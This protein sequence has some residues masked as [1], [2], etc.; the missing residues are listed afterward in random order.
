[1]KRSL[2]S[3][4][5]RVPAEQEVDDELALHLELR[6]RELMERGMDERAARAEARRRM[7]D[8]EGVRRELLDLSRRRERAMNLSQAWDEFRTDVRFALRQMRAAPLFAVVAITTLALGIGANGAIFALVDAAL[9]RPLP[10]A[11]PERLVAIRETTAAGAEGSASPLNLADWNARS[12]AFEQIAGY[13]GGVGGMVMAG[14][15]GNAET[16]SRQWTTAGIFDVLGV[17]AIAGRTFERADDEKRA[18]VVVLN[19]AF[20]RSRF[21]ADPS[22]VGREIRLDGTMF[23]IVGV[24]PEWFRLVGPSS[25]WAMRPTLNLPERARGVYAFSA[26]GRLRPG[27]TLDA[28]LRDLRGVASALSSEYPQTNAGRSVSMRPMRDAFVGSDLRLTSM[29]FLGVVGFVLLICCANVANLLLA[30]ATA[31]SR[32]LAIRAA[33]GGGRRRIARQLITES[34]V[35]STLGGTFGLALGAATLAVA[36]SLIPDGIVP[37]T[38]TLAF[39]LRVALFCALATLA[40]G[41]VF[42]LAPAVQAT[43]LSPVEA[44]GADVRTTAGGGGRFREALVMS[45]VATAV[46][47]LF[48]A[49]LLLRSLAEVTSFDRGYRAESVLTMLVDPLGSKYPT[50]E[51][52]QQFLDEVEREARSAPGVADV[53]WTSALPLG[54]FDTGGLSYEIVGDEPLDA[55]RRP[56]TEYQVVSPS[57]FAAVELPIVAGRPFDAR[58]HRTGP[59]VAIVN[60]AFVKALGGRSPIGLFIA[61]RSSG[62]PQ[63]E[64]RIREIV[65]VAKQVKGSPDE[66]GDF[67]QVYAP[68]TQ[69]PTDDIYLVARPSSGSAEALTAGLR[70]AISRVDREQLVS[71]RDIRTLADIEW[72]AVGRHRFRALLVGAFAFLALV[73]AMVG[74]FGILAYSVQQRVRD[75]GVRRALGASTSHIVRDLTSYGARVI[76]GGAAC[77]LVLAAILSRLIVAVLFGVEPLDLATFAGVL[78]I[79]ASGGALSILG[80]AWRAARIDPVAALRTK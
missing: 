77:G 59:P 71:V 18:N 64:P 66:R 39:D 79:L 30:R 36:P 69:A 16:V 12:R 60:E 52:L 2:R 50:P 74:V 3:I 80:P 23:T 28:G 37:A 47:L 62:S 65:G 34:L 20:W 76:G 7:G 68:I 63:A 58:D 53:G 27:V 6:A 17:K 33:L 56:T 15:D 32:E 41:V 8:V 31:R 24:V 57:Y 26:V 10:F 1:M 4:L 44:M 70:A 54:A 11:D 21:D 9:L 72:D 55:G 42:G 13:V 22:I 40:V 48:G 46:L 73:L 61:L 67:V 51:S 14:R 5:W 38:V 25:L 45:E 78:A 75:L 49:G 29:L 19:E 43:G 35:L